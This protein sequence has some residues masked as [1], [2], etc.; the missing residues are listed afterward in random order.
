M[1]MKIE[2]NI[3]PALTPLVEEVPELKIEP[4][5]IQKIPSKFECVWQFKS[6]LIS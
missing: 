1:Y 6:I 4:V 5:I 2:V 3:N